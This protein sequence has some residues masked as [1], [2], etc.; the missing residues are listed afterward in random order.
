MF[1]STFE[2]QGFLSDQITQVIVDARSKYA[3]WFQ[4]I[5]GINA[6]A[7]GVQFKIEVHTE[8]MWEVVAA[9]LFSRTLSNCQAGMLLCDRGM[10]V[11]ARIMFRC[12]IESLFTLVA[13]SKK[14]E[15][16]NQFITADQLRRRKL[17]H[18]VKLWSPAISRDVDEE[19]LEAKRVEIEKSIQELKPQKLSIQDMAGIAEMQDWYDT[20]Y[21][22]LSD[23]V[24]ASIRDLEKHLVLSPEREIEALKNEPEL[25]DQDVLF[26]MYAEIVLRALAAI[27]RVFGIP[28]ESFFQEQY[29]RIALL[30]GKNP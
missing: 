22:I 25:E 6:F 27:E 28:V 4:V 2:E 30:A 13:I 23:S 24:H 16:V 12:A 21:T 29:E 10:D 18:K 11:Q 5:T 8:D 14:P 3:E 15:V 19:S 7:Q 20:A 9:S 17:Y 1:M 26:T